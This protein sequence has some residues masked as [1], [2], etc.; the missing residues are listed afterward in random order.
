[1]K[2]PEKPQELNTYLDTHFTCDCGREHYASVKTVRIGAGALN[3]LPDVV[4]SLGYK[5]LYLI[6]DSITYK[7]A[8]QR[9]MEI[10]ESAGVKATIRTLT[11]AAFDEATVGELLIHM[12]MDTDLVVAVGT[13]SINDMSR[14]FS[15]RTG[16]PFMTI[17]TAAP[18]DG[19]ASS[20]AAL[21]VENLKTTYNAQ[22]P[23][24]I[25]GDTDILTGA[26]SRMIAAG[27]ADLLGKFTCLCDWK[28][29]KAI[30]N[31]HYCPQVVELVEDCVQTVLKDAPKAQERDPQVIGK[32]MEGLV[33]AGVAMSLYGNSRPA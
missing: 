11:H 25:I 24:A 28:L 1:M 29:A 10:L 9:A 15:F 30:N 12:P 7:I 23:V 32:I 16:R 6:S 13:G 4:E 8:G 20:V 5:S 33:L 21:N 14:F 27:L 26:P 19:F 22:P 18:M 31:E 3:Q 17:A 2:M